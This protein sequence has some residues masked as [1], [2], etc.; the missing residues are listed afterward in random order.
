MYFKF[1][2]RPP[3]TVFK[4]VSSSRISSNAGF[5]WYFLCSS[6]TTT[7]GFLFRIKNDGMSLR[8]NSSGISRITIATGN[9]MTPR[10]SPTAHW[11]PLSRLTENA[12]PPKKTIRICP[13]TMITWIRA[14]HLFLVIPSRI[15]NLLSTRR[16]LDGCQKSLHLCRS[17]IVSST[18]LY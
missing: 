16:Q 4:K 18:Y 6:E 3:L 12:D 15:L 14:N 1:F 17:T 7:S 9:D 10:T 5:H 8:M 2:S 13:P 11:G